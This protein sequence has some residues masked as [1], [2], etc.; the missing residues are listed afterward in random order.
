MFYVLEMAPAP[1]WRRQQEALSRRENCSLSHAYVDTRGEQSITFQFA[2]PCIMQMEQRERLLIMAAS[3]C[4]ITG[5]SLYTRQWR[6]LKLEGTEWVSS[7]G[8]KGPN[9]YL[10]FEFRYAFAIFTPRLA[11]AM[12][13]N[14][15]LFSLRVDWAPIQRYTLCIALILI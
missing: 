13:L 5:R 11:F 4:S 7:S 9:N 8:H 12:L 2:T 10:A 6:S 3:K 14:V 1:N 15:H